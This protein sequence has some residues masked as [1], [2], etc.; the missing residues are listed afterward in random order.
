MTVTRRAYDAVRAIAVA[1]RDVAPRAMAQVA[2]ASA[3]ARSRAAASCGVDLQAAREDASTPRWRWMWSR[4][5]RRCGGWPAIPRSNSR[6]SSS[7]IGSRRAGLQPK[8]EDVS[9]TA[10][11]AG[12]SCAARVR[13]GGAG[14]RVLLS[15]ETH[16]VAL[17]INSFSTP[18]AASRC[19]SSMSARARR[20]AAY[21]GKDVKGAMVLASGNVAQAVERAPCAPR[22]AAGVISTEIAPYTRPAE[23]P[24]VLQW[25]SIPVRRSAAMRSASRRRRGSRRG[26]APSSRKAPVTLHVDIETRFHRGRIARWSSRSPGRAQPD[27]RVVLAAHVQEPGANDNASGCGTLLAA[28][29]AMQDGIRRG[30]LPPPARTH[31]LSLGRRDQRQPAVGQGSSGSGEGRGR[32]AVARHDR[33]GHRE[34]RRHVPDREGARSVGAV[35]AAVGSAFGMGRGQ[36]RSGDWCA[37]AS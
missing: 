27:Q 24:D 23:T 35:G 30:A 2:A 13:L 10:D 9:P 15:K 36:G 4:S 25:G 28:A 17:A 16:R 6:S 19:G 7:S 1:A 34:D 5:W 18:P 33:R 3:A 37:A 12:S 14:G 11:R 26:C 22:G 32:D 29:L 31:H 8:Y 21:E 20:D